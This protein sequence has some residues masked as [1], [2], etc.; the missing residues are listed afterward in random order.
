MTAASGPNRSSI[1]P[2]D[3]EHGPDDV[4]PATSPARRWWPRWLSVATVVVVLGSWTIG[5]W[6]AA[7]VFHVGWGLALP[8]AVGAA[9]G[10]ARLLHPWRDIAPYQPAPGENAQLL[11]ALL[12]VIAWPVLYDLGTGTLGAIAVLLLAT[13]FA[14]SRIKATAPGDDLRLIGTVV[15]I[16][17]AGLLAALAWPLAIGLTVAAGVTSALR[18]TWPDRLFARGVGPGTCDDGRTRWGRGDLPWVNSALLAA[19]GAI[20]AIW[21][22]G[23]GPFWNGDNAYHLNKAEH[24]ARLPWSFAPQD[25][26]YG[27]DGL[28]HFP[29]VNFLNSY[30]PLLGVV[31]RFTGLGAWDATFALA[32]PLVA[33]L[34]PFAVRDAGRGLGVHRAGLAGGVAA[35]VLSISP[36]IDATFFASVSIGKMIGPVLLAPLL[37]GA[38]G[39]FVQRPT[40]QTAGLVIL[41]TIALLATSPSHSAAALL[42][43][44]A[45]TGIAAARWRRDAR[46]EG[47]SSSSVAIIA[48]P[49]VFLMSFAA[50]ARFF[51]DRA[52][53]VQQSIAV[54]FDITDGWMAWRLAYGDTAFWQVPALALGATVTAV[55]FAPAAPVVRRS[56]GAAVAL[57]YV[58]MLPGVFDLVV[59]DILD[60]RGYSYRLF[61]SF[62]ASALIGFALSGAD[63]S[64]FA[65]L[66]VGVAVLAIGLSGP[67]VAPTPLGQYREQGP[68][69]W[70]A[71]MAWPFEA[72][73]PADEREAADRMLAA[74]PV[75]GRFLAPDN[76]EMI[77]TAGSIDRYP[78]Y[79][80]Q[81][82]V[83]SFVVDAGTPPAFRAA[84][85]SL[86]DRAVN[87]T[88]GPASARELARALRLVDVDTVCVDPG[89]DPSLSRAL[90]EDFRPAGSSSAC[91][92]WVSEEP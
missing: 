75:G 67:E 11:L 54:V 7:V 41:A 92:L 43:I 79:V 81:Q 45:F 55:W 44:V 80:R 89:S 58:L 68:R 33:G 50:F 69:V 35:C 20:I 1:A 19:F 17:A 4:A 63:R 59:D 85:R 2:P 87:G 6:V 29:Y 51:Q 16:A 5:Y 18:P 86:L 42:L 49:L 77:A 74:T 64:R 91:Q 10:I 65:P 26:M 32:V 76:V 71:P 28:D 25:F 40:G 15:V 56:L 13:R 72:G 83:Q 22:A 88:G 23:F 34:I 14:T 3:A 82:F 70:R 57:V 30:E 39:R 8:I 53:P 27:V 84:E 9:V 48:A 21:V 31:G 73:A 78:T 12:L 52:D 38:A 90:S 47:R 24:Y 66:S 46:A 37:L 36:S 61:G 62:F 60:L